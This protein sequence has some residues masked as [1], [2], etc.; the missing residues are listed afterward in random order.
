MHFH[1]SSLSYSPTRLP[2]LLKPLGLLAVLL[3]RY[4]MELVEVMVLPSGHPEHK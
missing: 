2:S 3:P 1:L 4:P